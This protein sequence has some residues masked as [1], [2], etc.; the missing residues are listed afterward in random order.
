MNEDDT[1]IEAEE[2]Q[3]AARLYGICSL[4]A[5]AGKVQ[6]MDSVTALAVRVEILPSLPAF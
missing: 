3:M 1:V 6:I 5:W 2:S 4:T